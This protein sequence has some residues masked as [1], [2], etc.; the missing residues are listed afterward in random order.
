MEKIDTDWK[1]R[2]WK[3]QAKLFKIRK[4]WCSLLS[5]RSKQAAMMEKSPWD[6]DVTPWII[7]VLQPKL[8]KALLNMDCCPPTPS[9]WKKWGKKL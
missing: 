1:R 6:T 4:P 7:C 3:I 5:K 8:E 2:T 9:H